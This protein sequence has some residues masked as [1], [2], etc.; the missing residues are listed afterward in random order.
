[1]LQGGDNMNKE[2]LSILDEIKNNKTIE[3]QDIPNFRPRR[4][5]G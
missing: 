4:K 2:L 5:I 1:M 3:I